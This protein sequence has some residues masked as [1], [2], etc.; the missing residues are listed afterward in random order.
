M[1]CHIWLYACA[2]LIKYFFLDY[3][4]S[5]AGRED[6]D[7]KMLGKGVFIFLRFISMYIC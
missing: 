7:V 5:A 2:V 6:V 1:K 3:K 4:F